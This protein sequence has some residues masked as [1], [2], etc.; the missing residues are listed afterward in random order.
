MR[1]PHP[2]PIY[3]QYP[4]YLATGLSTGTVLPASSNTQLAAYTVI[5]DVVVPPEYERYVI[6]HWGDRVFQNPEDYVGYNAD[7]TGFVPIGNHDDDDEHG[8]EQGYLWVN[9]E[10]VSY[11]ASTL[12]SG[13]IGGL[14]NSPT[15][16][17]LV[18]GFSLEGLHAD[19]RHARPASGGPFPWGTPAALRRI[20]LQRGRVHPGYHTAQ[21]QGSVGGVPVPP[22][23]PPHP[24]I[25]GPR[26]QRDAHGRLRDGDVLGAERA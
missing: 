4:S 20:L 22:E 11:P 26:H 17:N 9:H 18:L 5:D 21:P 14:Q 13:I 2:L 6:V 23:K 8:G 3:Q 7:Y 25:V 12:A 16:D 24:R 10:Y 1:L 15:T 19:G